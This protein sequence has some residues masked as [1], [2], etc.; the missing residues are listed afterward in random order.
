MSWMM[1][2]ELPAGEIFFY[3]LNVQT[4]SGAHEAFS[5][6]CTGGSFSGGNVAWV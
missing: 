4:V 2:V 3:L 1:G 5:S 6:L